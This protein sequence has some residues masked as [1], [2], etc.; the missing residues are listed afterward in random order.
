[1]KKRIPKPYPQEPEDQPQT[2][3]EPEMTYET[4]SAETTQPASR[5]Y[6]KGVTEPAEFTA[7]EFA[8]LIAE[9]EAGPFY[10]LEESEKRF[11]EWKKNF[12]ES[13]RVK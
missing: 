2:V 5:S 12:R 8:D 9:A 13:R 11:E 3:H 6:S 7:E 10:T 1:M 4:A